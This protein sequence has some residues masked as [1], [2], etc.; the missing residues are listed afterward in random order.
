MPSASAGR[1]LTGVSMVRVTKLCTV[2]TANALPPRCAR[3]AAPPRAAPRA[4][5][6]MY[7]TARRTRRGTATVASYSAPA[8]RRADPTGVG[9]WGVLRIGTATDSTVLSHQHISS[10]GDRGVDR[11]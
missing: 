8:P 6:C 7:C 5:L 3:G 2:G 11:S 4:V 10:C 1:S 9:G